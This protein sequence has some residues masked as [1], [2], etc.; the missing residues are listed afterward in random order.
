MS[1]QAARQ[2]V[3]FS[4]NIFDPVYWGRKA[5]SRVKA[6]FLYHIHEVFSTALKGTFSSTHWMERFFLG[7]D[8]PRNDHLHEDLRP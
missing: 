6:F 1:W 2:L 3:P 5:V 4:A 8:C 7:A